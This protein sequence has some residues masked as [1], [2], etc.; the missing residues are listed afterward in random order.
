[1]PFHTQV[2]SQTLCASDHQVWAL[3]PSG[4]KDSFISVEQDGQQ[5]VVVVVRVETVGS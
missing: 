2:W 1:M 5:L 4:E 3:V